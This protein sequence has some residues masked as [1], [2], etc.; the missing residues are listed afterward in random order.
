MHWSALNAHVCCAPVDAVSLQQVNLRVEWKTLGRRAAVFLVGADEAAI[1]VKPWHLPIP[2][3]ISF[4]ASRSST[5]QDKVTVAPK[6]AS[7]RGLAGAVVI[8]SPAAEQ[9]L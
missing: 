3:A 7:L 8:V 9:K 5:P 1:R 4:P 2:N 6:A